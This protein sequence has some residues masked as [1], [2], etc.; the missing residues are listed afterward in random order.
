[1]DWF[2]LGLRR[3]KPEMQIHNAV[4]NL[5]VSGGRR[6]DDGKWH[7]LMVKNE[8]HMVLL[9]VDGDDHLV[10]SHVSYPIIEQREPSMRIGVGGLF[11]P[12]QELLTPLNTAMDGCIRRWD[13]LNQTAEW[14]EGTSLEE[15]GTKGC[16]PH[17][18][19]GSFFP[20]SGLATFSLTGLPTG[21]SPTN[22]SWSL[23]LQMGIEAAPQSGTLLA[24]SSLK[25]TPLL[26]LDLQHTDLVARLG[27]GTILL[28]PLPLK[29]CL[30]SQLSLRV[31]PSRLTLRL[32]SSEAVKPIPRGEYD[33]LKH[34][35]L[36]QRGHLVVGGQPGQELSAM[37][38]ERSYFRG[39]L[40][41]IRV[42]GQELDLDSAQSRSNSIWA[43][44][45]PGP[46]AEGKAHLDIQN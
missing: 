11:I 30:A 6:L 29:D 38:Q 25:Q 9:E 39:C 4:T 20:G 19:R 18:H 43:H 5:T 12:V 28:A 31:T 2:V 17:I 15:E 27:N 13:W 40:D 21:H 34:L 32:G 36:S 16:F 35:W 46:N 10:L 41:T 22:G 3:G 45:C 14:R 33:H 42:Q 7:R 23:T 44:T 24:I 37:A 1:M 8:G 26:R